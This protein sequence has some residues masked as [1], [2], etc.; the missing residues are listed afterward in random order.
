MKI[1]FQNSLLTLLFTVVL[2]SVIVAQAPDAAATIAAQKEAI[3]PFAPNYGI[4]RGQAFTT[5]PDGRKLEITQ[6]ERVG[7]FL[8]GSVMVLEGRGYDPKTGQCRL[9]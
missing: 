1:T 3:K 9:Q 2:A 4:W 5:L 7:P 6:T 8:D